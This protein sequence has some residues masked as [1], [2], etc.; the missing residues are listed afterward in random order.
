[1]ALRAL[2]LFSAF[3]LALGPT[4][5]Y[6]GQ[7]GS[8][9][10][11][12]VQFGFGDGS[13]RAIRSST[14][15]ST[16]ALLAGQAASAAAGQPFVA[17]R[18]TVA[19]ALKDRIGPDD[20]VFVFARAANGPRMPLAILRKQVRDLPLKFTLDDSLAMSPAATLSSAQRVVV[21]ARISKSGN[22]MTQPGDLQG[23]SAPVAPGASGLAIEIAE[24]VG[25]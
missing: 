8:W 2:R 5:P 16:L 19:A 21:G 14:P 23:F 9:H 22:A 17:G 1:M 4:T 6:A 13:V 18:V 7:F 25:R 12:V 11:G 24:V 20:T 3:P 10:T 15:G